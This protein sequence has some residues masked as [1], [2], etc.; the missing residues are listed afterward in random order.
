MIVGS[1][2]LDVRISHLIPTHWSQV[3]D[4]RIA[5]KPFQR[6]GSTELCVPASIR[7]H[8]SYFSLYSIFIKSVL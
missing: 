5:W 1:R 7:H 6:P 3:K 8:V 2:C 4:S